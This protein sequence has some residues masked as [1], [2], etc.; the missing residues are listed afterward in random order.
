MASETKSNTHMLEFQTTFFCKILLYIKL[1]TFW[2]YALWCP[3]LKKA[4][5]LPTKVS[6]GA[7]LLY[8]RSNFDQT[9]KDYQQLVYY[10]D[11]CPQFHPNLNIFTFIASFRY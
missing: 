8:F 1:T 5:P 6:S 3:R 7:K 9:H 4:R 10:Q 2:R 11:I